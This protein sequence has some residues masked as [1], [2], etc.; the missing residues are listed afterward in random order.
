MRKRKRQ[1]V[2]K[3]LNL[4]EKSLANAESYPAHDVNVEGKSFL[5]FDDWRG[6]SGHPLWMRNVMIPARMR[7]RARKE[8][9]LEAIAN[10]GKNKNMTR[11]KRER[12]DVSFQPADELSGVSPRTSSVGRCPGLTAPGS[13]REQSG[14]NHD[15]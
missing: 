13:P 8:K 2:E 7:Q 14:D 4:I 1:E 11:R 15:R 5:H 3:T 12:D 9:A 6:K 10:K